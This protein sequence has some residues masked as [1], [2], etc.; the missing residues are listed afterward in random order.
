MTNS[1][2]TVLMYHYVRDLRNSRYPEIRGLDIND[3][4]AQL[5][6]LEKHYTFVTIE[7]IINTIERQEP[8]PQ[9]AALLTF[10]D[11]YSDHFNNVFPL[12]DERSIQ[13]CFYPEV[14]AIQEQRVL[15]NHKIHFVLAAA[16]NSK[17][18]K[19]F[20]FSILDTIRNDYQ[21]ETK[22]Y[23]YEKLA[24][25]SKYDS[26]DTIFVKR[27]LQSELPEQVREE[28]ANQLFEEFVGVDQRVFSKE[29]YLDDKQVRCMINHG[30]HFGILGYHH[31]RYD[32]MA[33]E[34]QEKEIKQAA[35]YLLEV[36][37]NSSTLSVSYPW[38]AYNKETLEIMK[39]INCKVGFTTNAA[40]ADLENHP[41][42]ELPRLDTNEIPKKGDA[43]PN[44]WYLEP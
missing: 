12:L 43:S 8:L 26:K 32:T 27:L 5:D 25:A 15:L 3:F 39:S 19:D 24:K 44:R 33:K 38:G 1:K 22:E 4:K 34:E 37:S 23:Y 10:N 36:G 31:R 42:L 9:K 14:A 13:G 11:S 21:L 2:V 30:M 17:K 40:V 41:K 7:Q 35:K 16:S 28:V 20:I 29:L 6:Y 18:V